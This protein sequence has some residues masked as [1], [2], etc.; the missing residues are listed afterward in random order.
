MKRYIA[1]A[2]GL[3]AGGAMFAQQTTD[4]NRIGIDSA[5]QN[6]QEISIDKF[7]HDSYWRGSISPDDGFI[8]VRLFEGSP[9]IQSEDNPNG[10]API[11]AEEGL[12]RP[13]TQVLGVRVDFLHRGNVSFYLYPRRPIPIEGITKTISVWAVGRN[14]NHTLKIL[15]QDF[16]GRQFE[17]EVGKLNFQGWKKLTVA[18]PPQPLTGKAGIIQRDYHYNNQLGIKVIGFKVDCDP[19]ETAGTYYLYLDD[20]R[21]VTD[22]FAEDNRDPDDMADAW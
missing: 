10:K 11:A 13:D 19:S 2:L 21:A 6:L 7:E 9:A 15:V 17:L 12:N 4:P 5:Q 3:L 8:N 22:L 1:I 16:F 14:F 20:L 18:I